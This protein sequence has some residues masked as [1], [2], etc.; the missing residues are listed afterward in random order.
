MNVRKPAQPSVEVPSPAADRPP[1]IKVGLIAAAGFVIGVA[2]PR[3]A[4]IHL[5]PATPPEANPSAPPA[6]SQ[7]ERSGSSLPRAFAESTPSSSF[8]APPPQP[9]S[10]ASAPPLS[11]PVQEIP[12]VTVNR[13]VVLSCKTEEGE[14]KKGVTDCGPVAGFDGI[15]Q[16]RLRR[17]AA[18]PAALGA[19]GKLSVV[20]NVDFPSNRV[21]VEVGKSSTVGHV[22]GFA[23][24]VKPAFQG[25]SLGALDHQNPHYALFYSLVFS[26][27]D[28]R[29]APGAGSGAASPGSLAGG[30]TT[31]LSSASPSSSSVT[32]TDAEAGTAQVIWE[33]AIVR[34]TPRT[35]QVLARLQRGT[36]LRLGPSQDGWYPVKYGN[37][38]SSEGWVYRGAIGR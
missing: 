26:P 27:K 11:P 33:V 25:V 34:D 19:N 32:A 10:V 29:G 28:T 30:E 24:C 9:S 21:A 38:F 16:P 12:L 7:P 2:W 15:A 36:K 13:G 3:L 14:A 6:A 20:F 18:C 35:G 37:D 1:W 23:A 8:P 31:P 17:L 5:G 4:G 22:D